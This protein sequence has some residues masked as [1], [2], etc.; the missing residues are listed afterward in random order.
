MYE[1]ARVAGRAAVVARLAGIA[2]QHAAYGSAAYDLDA[3]DAQALQ[4][5]PWRPSPCTAV[6]GEG[7]RRMLDSWRAMLCFILLAWPGE[8]ACS[9]HV[10]CSSP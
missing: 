4:V 5:P 1:G 9:L 6:Q 3:R 10:S 2:A 8:P 7:R